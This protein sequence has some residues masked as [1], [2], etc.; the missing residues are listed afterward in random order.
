[1]ISPDETK[2]LETKQR[3]NAHVMTDIYTVQ[4]PC[5][6]FSKRERGS[7]VQPP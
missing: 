6:S 4:K 7:C 1:M 5:A 2:A 3:Y